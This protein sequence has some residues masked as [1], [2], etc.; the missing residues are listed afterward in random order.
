MAYINFSELKPNKGYPLMT[1]SMETK[2]Y[3]GQDTI[4]KF[5]QRGELVLAQFSRNRDV[6][7]NSVIPAEVLVLA[8]GK[9]MWC[10]HLAHYVDKYNVRLPRDFEKHILGN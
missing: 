7:D 3:E 9:Y 8:D 1:D 4:V 5:L 2:R 6:F 10:N